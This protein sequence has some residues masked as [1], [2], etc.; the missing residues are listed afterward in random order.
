MA[1]A[2]P[3]QPKD[4]CDDETASLLVRV[5]TESSHVYANERVLSCENGGLWV[6]FALL[7]KYSLPSVATYLLQY[8]FTIIIIV[9]A[10]HL[11]TEELAAASIGGTTMAIIG[12]AIFEGMATAL[13]TLCA[14]AY[15]SGQLT[16]VGLHVQRMTLLM[17]V[18]IIPVGAF[19]LC[20][21]SILP[22]VL[23]DRGLGVRAG[24]FIQVSL[25]GLP[26]YAYFEAGKRFLQAQGDFRSGMI[27]LVVC[28]PVNIF[29]SWLFAF[30][31][32]MG[33]EGAAL[34]QSLANNLR[35]ILL[36]LY[37]KLF[38]KWSHKCWTSWSLH[39][40]KDWGPMTKLAVAGSVVNLGE[41]LA[42][43]VLG[44]LTSYLGT[45]YLA[46]QAIVN[47]GCAIMWHI[48]LSISIAVAT[49]IGHL[50]GSG[51][52]GVARQATALYVVVFLVVGCFNGCVLYLLRHP[53]SMFM[54]VDPVVQSIAEQS[55]WSVAVFQIIDAINCGCNGVMR[56]LGLQSIAACVVMII[57]YGGSV[58]VALWLMLGPPDFKLNGLWMGMGFGCCLIAI[59]ECVY[60]RFIDWEER[61]QGTEQE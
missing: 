53:I 47:S 28:T 56:G 19:W 13:D 6:E 31:L 7:C 23:W 50:I 8:S 40:L 9:I 60:M 45:E 3:S 4:A 16:S 25:L 58:P 55:M 33:L 24:R 51:L 46:A 29:L 49:R 52:P 44:V 41:W 22:F 32:N 34:G 10:G 30:K 36:F 11:G 20:S 61:C 18:T 14:Q 42:F 15:G 57:N 27:V 1:N 38:C 59:V 35:P 5:R 17:S 37:A 43:E 12:Y 39:C 54:S 26:G 48:P 21:P 2:H